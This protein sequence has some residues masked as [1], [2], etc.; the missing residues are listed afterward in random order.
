MFVPA[1]LLAYVFLLS[2]RWL[3]ADAQTVSVSIPLTAPTSAPSVPGAL[4][5]FSI[6]QD[7]WT[8]W[9][10]TTSRND[11]W[12]NLLSNLKDITGEPPHIRI[13]ADSEDHTDFSKTVQYSETIFPASNPTTPYPEATNVTVGSAYYQLASQLP[14]GTQVTWGVNFGTNNLTA[15]YLETQAIVSAFTSSAM[16]SAGVT[17]ESIEIG[18]EADLYKNNGHRNSSFNIQNY[19]SQWTTFA[20]NVTAVANAALGSKVALW[21]AS[22]AGSSHSATSGFSPQSAIQDGLLKSSAGEQIKTISQHH[23]EGS[24][25]SGSNGL[26]QDL[27]S[28]SHTRGNLSSFSPDITAVQQQGLQYVLGETNSYSCHGAPGVS[29]VAG[30]ALWGL[31]YALYA[32][33][34]GVAR[35]HFHEGIG[36]KYNFLQPITLTR[37]ILDGS[38]LP[39]PLAPHIQPLYYAAIIAGEAIGSSGS[40]KAVELSI[41][42]SQVAGYAF[43]EGSAL[44]R[45]LFIN[46]QSFVGGTRGSVHIAPTFSGGSKSSMTVKRLAIPLAN[47]TSGVTWGGQTYE[48]SDGK[49]SGSMNTTTVS[50]SAGFDLHDTEAV[51]V[52][53]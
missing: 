44:K 21:G 36:Y 40:A 50:V 8:D 2:L 22:F 7:R 13:G 31:D 47:A 17:L 24:F 34:I 35:V 37:S 20:Q 11:Y 52:S 10:G 41:S 26:L 43:F 6:E 29:N 23:Y 27:M 42:N 16:K 14:S 19:V 12:F 5:S 48:T 46:F 38:T 25:C 53:F 51:L 33:Q 30:T 28:K 32:T 9:I 3:P 39:S 1:S 15:A 45:A 4:I 49:V 18:N